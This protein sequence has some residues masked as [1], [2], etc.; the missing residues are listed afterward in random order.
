MTLDAILPIYTSEIPEEIFVFYFYT[1]FFGSKA[2]N[3]LKNY[4]LVYSM[5][6]LVARSLKIV[7]QF[8]VFMT[9]LFGITFHEAGQLKLSSLH[10][11]E[12]SYSS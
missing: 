2:T 8:G 6:R 5:T 10:V 11:K 4:L 7:G 9:Q 12:K 1:V 3:F